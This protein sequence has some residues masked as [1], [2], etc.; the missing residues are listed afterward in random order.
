[1]SNAILRFMKRNQ[2]NKFIVGFLA[3]YLTG[4]ILSLSAAFLYQRHVPGNH[5][6]NVKSVTAQVQVDSNDDLT[7]VFCRSPR[8]SAIVS[9]VNVRTF[10]IN[11]EDNSTDVFTPAAQEILP[12]VAYEKRDQNCLPLRISPDKRPNSPGKYYFC[13]Q[14]KFKAY[15]VDKDTSFCSTEYEIIRE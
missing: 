9:D 4:A 8:Y 10:Y 7:V 1:M 3:I 11:S 6:L 13:Q 5:L 14:I 12:T 2:F 15:G